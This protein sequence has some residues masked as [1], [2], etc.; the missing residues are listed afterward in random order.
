MPL[1]TDVVT[2]PTLY[3]WN[4]DQSVLRHNKG[5]FFLCRHLLLCNLTYIIMVFHHRNFFRETHFKGMLLAKIITK[6]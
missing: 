4:L 3:H 6:V 1:N 2:L 5:F